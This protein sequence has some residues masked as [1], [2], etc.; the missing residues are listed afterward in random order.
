MD[1]HTLVVAA[2][3]VG[4][5]LIAVLTF[6]WRTRRTFPGF[7]YWILQYVAMLAGLLALSL[8]GRAPE[9]VPVLLGNGLLFFAVL[10]VLRGVR[11]FF[12]KELLRLPCWC[13][14]ALFESALAWFLYVIPDVRARILLFSIFE[15]TAC[16]VVARELLLKAPARLLIPSR[17]TG[18]VMAGYGAFM[19]LRGPIR[20]LWLPTPTFLAVNGLDGGIFLVSMAVAV[21]GAFGFVLMDGQR[22]ENEIE[23]TRDRLEEKEAYLKTIIDSVQTGVLI[24]DAETR[25]ILDAN[26]V[27]CALLGELKEDMVGAVC[28]Q[29]LCPGEAGLCPVADLGRM[30]DGTEGEVVDRKGTHIPVIKSVVEV[31]ISGRTCFLES[32]IDV[33]RRRAAEEAV[34]ESERLLRTVFDA[35]TDIMVLKDTSFRYGAAN[36]VFCGLAGKTEKEIVGKT[37]YDLFT[38]DL[39]DMFRAGDKSVV[40]T[41]QPFVQDERVP[42]PDG[43]RFA[44][45]VKTPVLDE[46]GDCVAIVAVMRDITDRKRMEEALRLSE[47]KFSLA[48]H[49]SP[50]VMAIVLTKEQAI[51]RGKQGLRRAHRVQP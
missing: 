5:L 21:L 14:L 8:R 15:G 2:T 46:K 51:H 37:D 32:F 23:T 12:G 48:F 36:P 9:F 4:L 11:S 10:L 6:I 17:F 41:G 1:V 22:L 40:E 13:A 26:A 20:L 42:G 47:K 18:A 25:M 34:R 30:V 28:H 33:S 31:T 43:D 29:Y 19:V 35:S 27:A 38:S 44:S 3:V 7:G 50:A 45:T 16:L 24:I 39:A 49:A